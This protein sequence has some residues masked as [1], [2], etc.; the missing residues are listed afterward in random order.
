MRR[1]SPWILTSGFLL[2]AAWVA[3]CASQKEPAE[4]ALAQIEASLAEIRG[5]AARYAADELQAVDASLGT[6]KEKLAK[7]D[8]KAVLAEAPQLQSALG[9]LKDTVANKKAE[10]QAAMA[11]ARE[12]WN[13]LSTDVP[14]MVAA[15]Q[16]RVDV[17][18]QSRKLP[19]N[20]SQSAFDSA[21]SGLDAM[22]S[23]WAEATAAYSSGDA[24][25]AVDK[26]NAA[27]QKGTE[28]LQQLGMKSG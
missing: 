23:S 5:D 20:V 2:A 12:Q 26:A 27:R 13:S 18:G 4:K 28:V 7:G 9:S 1:I 10:A 15:I 24:V 17:L 3:G 6:L 21:K 8:Y 14:K 25:G 19:N 16:S 22:K 11:A